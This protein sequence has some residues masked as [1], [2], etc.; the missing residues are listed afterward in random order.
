M[1][2]HDRPFDTELCRS[3]RNGARLHGGI[4]NVG[5]VS[6]FAPAMPRP[7]EGDDERLARERPGKTFSHVAE[8][9][10]RAMNENDGRD[11][12]APLAAGEIVEPQPFEFAVERDELARW[13]P[14]RARPCRRARRIDEK[15]AEEENEKDEGRQMPLP[16]TSSSS[17][18]MRS[19]PFRSC[20]L[21]ASALR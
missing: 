19:L 7:V 20:G 13:R 16:S 11:A 14:G 2:H 8:I 5:M 1:S 10:A 4:G 15:R 18:A 12:F 9:A 6:A 3:L 21:I 17:G